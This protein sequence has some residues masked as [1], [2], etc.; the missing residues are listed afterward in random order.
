MC[1]GSSDGRQEV[2][3][4]CIDT[5]PQII[6]LHRHS[7]FGLGLQH[8]SFLQFHRKIRVTEPHRRAFIGNAG[9][10]CTAARRG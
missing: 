4:A 10:G 1:Y 6:R 8:Q 3:F 2:I 7:C 5:H 9:S